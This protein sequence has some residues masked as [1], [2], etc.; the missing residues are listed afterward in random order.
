[1]PDNISEIKFQEMLLDIW[2]NE[3]GTLAA[4]EKRSFENKLTDKRKRKQKNFDKS[5]NMPFVKNENAGM[6]QLS[7]VV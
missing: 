1:M 5:L 4:D 2:E 3:G 7:K 6:P